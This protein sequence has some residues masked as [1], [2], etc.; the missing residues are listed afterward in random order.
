MIQRYKTEPSLLERIL[1]S[2]AGKVG[3][4]ML[5]FFILAAFAEFLNVV[6]YMATDVVRALGWK[7]L[8]LI[9]VVFGVL[10][11]LWFYPI[12]SDDV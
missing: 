10:V 4:L 6:I 5:G 2:N 7:E 8:G 11:T 1:C 9:A 12:G 3:V